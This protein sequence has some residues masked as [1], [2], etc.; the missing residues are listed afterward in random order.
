MQPETWQ[1]HVSRLGCFVKTG[2]N[3]LD[4]GEQ[5]GRNSSTIS[6]LEQA[7][8]TPVAKTKD[9]LDKGDFFGMDIELSAKPEANIF[10]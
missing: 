5:R 9:H 7:L 6:L 8:K 3:A 1:V 2:E 10:K 4:L